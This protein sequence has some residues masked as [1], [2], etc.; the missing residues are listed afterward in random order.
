MRGQEL[1]HVLIDEKLTKAKEAIHTIPVLLPS[2]ISPAGSA[3]S[4]YCT[5]K[6]L[7]QAEAA[8]EII[9]FDPYL[10]MTVFH[11]YLQALR[12]SV[13]IILVT[14][15]PGAN[16]SNKDKIRWKEFLDISQLYAKQ[17]PNRYRLVVNPN[18]HD[19]WL[20]LD[21]KR[22]IELGGSIKDAGINK[23]FSITPLDSTA[24]NIDNILNHAT[25]GVEWFGPN[26]TTHRTQ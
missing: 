18:L 20:L 3:F 23:A 7:L 1:T 4:T 14:S 5:L 9:V 10:D 8:T 25:Q 6:N 22:P 17:W 12:P 15:E 13:S 16:A 26:V 2:T 24:A 11:R 19:R 21:Q